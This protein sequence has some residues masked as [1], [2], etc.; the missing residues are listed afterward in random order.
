MS[1]K[2]KDAY[3]IGGFTGLPDFG[4]RYRLRMLI[5]GDSGSGKSG[6]AATAPNTIIADVEGQTEGSLAVR[7]VGGHAF[8]VSANSET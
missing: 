4:E 7:R 1:T 8:R 6:L 5:M 3:E 2:L